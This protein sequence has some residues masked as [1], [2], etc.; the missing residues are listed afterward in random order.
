[1]LLNLQERNKIR[2]LKALEE[3]NLIESTLDDSLAR[4]QAKHNRW[5]GYIHPSALSW[6]SAPENQLKKLQKTFLPGVSQLKRMQIG[7]IIHDDIQSRIHKYLFNSKSHSEEHIYIPS[8]LFKGT[9]DQFGKLPGLGTVLIEYKSVSSY[10]QDSNFKSYLNHIEI[11]ET[12]PEAKISE[13]EKRI[14]TRYVVK[15]VPDSEHLTQTFTY[16]LMIKEKYG[17]FPD[18]ALVCYLR[19]DTYETM[20]FVYKISNHKDLLKKA[21]DNYKAVYALV[22]EA[23]KEI[24]QV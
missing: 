24:R 19:K 10:Q 12:M 18:Y 11:K 8:M 14:K 13:T 2:L 3:G 16:A 20:E 7:T 4:Q 15:D 9:P 17:Y 22:K 1:M 5:D 6:A 21:L 23:G